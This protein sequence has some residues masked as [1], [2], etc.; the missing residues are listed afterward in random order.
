[1]NLDQICITISK[2]RGYGWVVWV[3]AGLQAPYCTRPP[4]L[5]W[6]ESLFNSSGVRCACDV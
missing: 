4:P 1:M 2:T 6:N 3:V 5:H